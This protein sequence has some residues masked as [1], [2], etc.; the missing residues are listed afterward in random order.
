[1]GNDKKQYDT[2]LGQIHAK[3]KEL[4]GDYSVGGP[5]LLS[6]P[7]HNSADRLIMFVHHLDQYVV[8]NEAE[9]PHVF[10]NFENMVGEYSSYNNIAQDDFIVTKIIEKYPD[11]PTAKDNQIKLIFVQNVHTGEHDVIVRKDVED[12]TEKY[13]FQ[14]NNRFLDSYKE[15][16]QIDKGSVLYRP[17]SYDRYGNYGFGK[18]VKFMYLVDDDTIEDAIIV[19]ETL[20]K[21]MLSTEV[22]TVK[23]PIN[24]NDILVNIFGD[25]DNYKAFPDVGEKT[26][27]KILCVKRRL[28]RDQ[29]LFDMK[30]ANTRR[31]LNS[32][33][34]TYIDGEVV[35]IDIFCNK[36]ID[37][38]PNTSFNRQ[39]IQYIEMSKKFYGAV[40]EYTQTLIDADPSKCS[41]DIKHWNSRA[42]DLTAENVKFRDENASA[43]SHIVMYVTVKRVVGLSKGQKLTGRHGNKGVISKILPD[44]LM[45]HTE[46]GEIVHIIF[47][48]LGAYNRLTISPLF[49]QSITFI[50][51]RVVNRMK[52]MT[53]IKDKEDLLFRV[54]K[55]FNDTEYDTFKKEYGKMSK[56]EKKEFFDITEKYG[57]FI[58]VPPFFNG[59]ML[60]ACIK[61]CYDTFD[62]I[63]PYKTYNYD[64]TSQRWV[65][66]MN[67]QIIGDMYIMKLKQNSKKNLSVTSNA[68]INKHGVPEKTDSAKVHKTLNSRTPIR[69][70]LQ[71]TI[72]NMISVDPFLSARLHMAYRNSPVARRELGKT[73]IQNYGDNKPIELRFTDKMTN[74]NVEILSAYLLS[75]GLTLEF[76]HDEL[77][78]REMDGQTKSHRYNGETY[79]ATPEYMLDKVAKDIVKQRMDD[80]ELGYIY[81][82]GEGIYKDQLIDELAAIIKADIEEQGE[83]FFKHQ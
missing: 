65:K 1:M 33:A 83:E 60:Y 36:P 25:E 82:G 61:E 32:D 70:G 21:T 44:Y 14:Y 50:T 79:I 4:R 2:M 48:S 20:A 17:T 55:I 72:N 30:S 66:M 67:D 45:P 54:L 26:K 74:R 49:E 31:I 12:L 43:F 64:T 57:I 9:L 73:I 37:E 19:S 34:N 77:D 29:R 28:N 7:T 10:T 18:N 56:D 11:V 75:M 62:W 53:N 51:S 52:T 35:D 80:N 41:E 39:L 6:I 58:H 23:I 68:P 27:N 46:T 40:A 13:G 42:K 22:E 63:K 71:E 15:G 8:P 24:D 78:I 5:T 81:I 69:S 59:K 76:D 47:N 16:D 38:I 3:A